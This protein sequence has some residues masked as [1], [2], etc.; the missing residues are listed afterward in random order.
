MEAAALVATVGVEEPGL[1]FAE[2]FIVDGLLAGL[3]NA[4]GAKV[5]ITGL[6]V[7][8]DHT[9]KSGLQ[10]AAFIKAEAL[11]IDCE[12]LYTLGCVVRT[13]IL[14]I[15]D[16]G[17]AFLADLRCAFH[18]VPAVSSFS[19]VLIELV[20]CDARCSGLCAVRVAVTCYCVGTIAC[21]CAA[22]ACFSV[23][24][25]CSFSVSADLSVCVAS[26]RS[27][28][29]CAVSAF[30][31]AEPS[32]LQ[33]PV[34]EGVVG[35]TDLTVDLVHDHAA[36]VVKEM[37]YSI[38]IQFFVLIFQLNPAGLHDSVAFFAEIVGCAV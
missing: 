2:I 1:V 10:L 15:E 32:G 37:P 19:V 4:I 31:Q 3:H 23:G 25:A 9:L 20:G 22:F 12:D 30:R 5:V 28:I 8:G 18:L 34:L 27:S 17:L 24:A 13:A 21:V 38:L 29:C 26:S 35:T 6:S 7:F 36:I 33:D 14:N 11:A 16:K